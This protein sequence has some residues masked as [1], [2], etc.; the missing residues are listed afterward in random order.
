M[1]EQNFF[2]TAHHRCVFSP[3]NVQLYKRASLEKGKIPAVILKLPYAEALEI[4][5]GILAH[6]EEIEARQAEL[7]A[8][9]ARLSKTFL[10]L[11]IVGD[12]SATEEQGSKEEWRGEIVYMPDLPGGL[13]R[14]LGAFTQLLNKAY[15]QLKEQRAL[16]IRHWC[17]EDEEQET[18]FWR[19][20]E[21]FFYEHHRTNLIE[22]FVPGNEAEK[23]KEGQE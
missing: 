9:F 13:S 17:L 2:D 18:L 14:P 21:W 3:M 22:M 16:Q 19:A 5:S 11:L 4:A 23:R 6:Q 15:Q 1:S 10:D 7:D 12:L 8:Q 20:F